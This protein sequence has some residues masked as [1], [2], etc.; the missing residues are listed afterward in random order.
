MGE[1]DWLAERFEANSGLTCAGGRQDARP[2]SETDDARPGGLARLSAPTPAGRQPRRL[3]DHHRR[4]GV[5]GH[6]AWA[7]SPTGGSG[8]ELPLL[9]VV[10]HEPEVVDAEPVGQL[11]LLQRV[12]EQAVLVAWLPGAGELVLVEDPESH[13]GRSL[14]CYRG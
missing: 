1:G 14:R 13:G 8:W 10:L 7:R 9:Q 4:A 12:G 5:P 3:V 11:D 2:L 6:A